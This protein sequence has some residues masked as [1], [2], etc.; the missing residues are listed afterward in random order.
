MRKKKKPQVIVLYGAMAVGKLT[1]AKI[2]AKKLNYHVTHNHLI[3]NLVLSVFERETLE[4]N[5]I[6][7]KLK[8]EF[9][10]LCV[11]SSKNIVIT[12]CYAHD[13]V[14][15]TGLKDPIYMKRLETRLVN[16]GAD[17]YFV[18][19]KASKAALLSRV[20]NKDRNQYH[21]LTKRSV[22][23]RFL[24]TEDFETSAPVKSNLA[25]DNSN[26][27]PEATARKIIKTLKL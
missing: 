2:I 8:Y 4:A 11:K 10:E 5:K 7:E 26:L 21:K 9:Y 15:P 13:Y 23:R 14:S 18:H 27:S 25:I 1:V 6:M 19:L 17:V 16:A 22:L 20:A 3:N 24:K 12:H